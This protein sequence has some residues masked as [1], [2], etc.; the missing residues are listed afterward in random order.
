MNLHLRYFL[1]EAFSSLGRGGAM[2]LVAVLTLT[3]ASMSGGAYFLL[4]QNSLYWLGQA[5]RRFEVVVYLKDGLDETGA[6]NAAEK[7]KA[8]GR[9]KDLTLVS[10]AEAAKDLAKDQG[11][12]DY[13]QV[14]GNENPLP[15]AAH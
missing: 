7:I 4:R 13:F 11:L 3:L 2:S 15:W 12:K 14:L 5:E 1:K 6:R 10:P 8:L 9:V